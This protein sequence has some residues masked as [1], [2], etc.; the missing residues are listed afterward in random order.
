MFSIDQNCHSLW[1]VVP[2]LQALARRRRAVTHFVEDIDVAFTAVGAAVDEPALRIER[3]RYHPGGGGDWGAALFYSEF[4]GRLPVEVRDWEPLIGMKVPALARRLGRT[5]EDLYDEFSPSDNWQWIGSSYVG[6]RDHHRVIA[7]L[8][9]AEAA[10]FVR[11]VMAKARADVLRAFPEPAPA[12]RAAAW[13]DR[14]GRRL[15]TLL[16]EHAGGKL[17]DLYRA[18]LGEYVGE[19][20]ELD[21]TSNLFALDAPAPRVQ[22]LEVF[23]A[24]Y[25]QAAGLY[26]EALAETGTPL[27]RLD[28]AGGELPFF[29]VFAHRGH[30]V[31][32]P[33]RLAGGQ[34]LAGGRS[35]PL[36]GGRVPAGA[37]ARAGIRG[38]SPKAVV[39]VIQACLHQDGASLAMPYRGSLYVPAVRR[40]AGKLAAAGLL[41]DRLG[42]ITRVRFR[43]LDRMR[44]LATRIRL[45]EHLT[46]CFGADEIAA[47]D[48][49]ANWADLAAEAAGRLQGLAD[50]AGRARWQE[51]ALPE[52]TRRL[53][54]L[55]R[56]RRQLART[57]PKAQRLRDLSKQAKALETERIDR[58][59]RQI[60]RDWQV[61]DID[62]WDSR[63][64]LLPWSIALGG[65][66]FYDD[67][68]ARAEVYPEPLA[69]DDDEPTR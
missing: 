62:Y 55:D 69:G 47:A 10:E 42:P 34:L 61:R 23:C 68:L 56:R 18:W 20:V 22:M 58:T 5:V 28:A 25:A 29:A 11:E 13:F 30:T 4:L 8:S 32:S 3:E 37:M 39:L 53:A 50:P 2:K 14:E 45:P 63:G 65:E 38:L 41:P 40:L 21:L 66:G 12:G 60:A 59:V 64:A 54:D 6:D 57:D 35:F 46:A 9:V 15:E 24:D 16:A 1:D 44:G 67:L 52:L 51:S 33:I 27:R 7:D 43:L 49:G 31:R 36:D 17:T 19:P 26:N 48:L